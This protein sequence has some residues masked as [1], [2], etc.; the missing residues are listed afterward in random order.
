MAG[1]AFV[2]K[3]QVACVFLFR[4]CCLP[5]FHTV[6]FG[7]VADQHDHELR[8]CFQHSILCS[9]R[10]T[11]RIEKHFL[12]H[13][14]AVQFFQYP[15][16][17]FAHFNGAGQWTQWLFVQGCNT[18]IP[19]EGIA[20]CQVHDRRRIALGK[21][22]IQAMAQIVLMVG[23]SSRLHVTGCTAGGIVD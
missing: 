18:A 19:H 16:Y 12:V 17:G 15:R 20:P 4:K 3:N 11:K 6:V 1:I 23:E 21:A 7:I 13:R 9:Y 2:L 5:S 10:S 14:R 22:A 8:Q